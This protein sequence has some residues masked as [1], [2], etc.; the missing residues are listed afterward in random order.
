MFCVASMGRWKKTV[1]SLNNR[2]KPCVPV[3]GV[4]VWGENQKFVVTQVGGWWVRIMEGALCVC[5]C[6]CECVCVPS[7][8]RVCHV[9]FMTHLFHSCG[10]IMSE[11]SWINSNTYTHT[12]VHT[13]RYT[14]TNKYTYT[15]TYTYK[16]TYAHVHKGTYSN[17]YQN[18]Y[19]CT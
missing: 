3:W 8:G 6:V 1:G 15:H 10:W 9:F 5:V 16:F 19:V 4:S 13:Y 12:H 2:N 11:I 18:A 7:G 17:I 14:H